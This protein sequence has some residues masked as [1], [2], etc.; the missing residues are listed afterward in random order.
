VSRR[1]GTIGV[2]LALALGVGLWLGGGDVA[3]QPKPGG[4][5]AANAKAEKG[6]DKGKDK[7]GAKGDK[8]AD[9][10]DKAAD[11]K[12]A[13]VPPEGAP[14]TG[15]LPPGHPP[16][17]DDGEGGGVPPGGAP[18]GMFGAAQNAVT[19]DASLP[20][21]TVVIALRD[22]EDKPLPRAPLTLVVQRSSVARGDAPPQN[23]VRTTDD[24]GNV[25]FDNLPVGAGAQFRATSQRGSATYEAPPFVLDD[26]AG[27]RVT[28]HAY[29]VTSDIDR[30]MLVMESAVY[31][32]LKEDSLS[33]QQY[34]GVMNGGKVAWAPENVVATLPDGFRAFNKQDSMSDAR[35]EEV[36]GKG[37]A[38]RGTFA[39][40][41]HTLDFHYTVP[42]AETERQT[43]RLT[44]PPHAVHMR[45]MVEASKKMGL[46]ADGFPAAQRRPGRDGKPLLITER[47]ARQGEGGVSTVEVTL[48]GLPTKGPGRWIAVALGLSFVAG[49]VGYVAKRRGSEGALDDDTRRDLREAQTALLDE[50]VALEK[51]HKS[52]EVGPKT[53][54][55]VRAALL[56]ALARI[57]TM[58][59]DAREA[60]AARRK[61][62]QGRGAA[63]ARA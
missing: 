40:G 43:I 55:R 25:R 24:E 20:A 41:E 44:L 21:G 30:T 28:L 61:G 34:F 1:S 35:I 13:P 37:V 31:I 14:P 4:D 42:L 22:G 5:K 16:V 59:D 10:G 7:A 57:V 32:S 60:R 53:Y 26:K 46:E 8:A 23:L 2:G 39:P 29:D 47:D 12:P 6:A 38:L 58:L 49:G 36:P 54:A 50:I 33:V 48:T 17:D 56:D 11:A 18:P 27:K 62:G 63:S 15:S 45:V 3:A 9:K 19:V 52:G 51:A